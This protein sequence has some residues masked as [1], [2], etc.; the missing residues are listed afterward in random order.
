MLS[1]H[2]RN[3]HYPS[4]GNGNTA[5]NTKIGKL[6]RNRSYEHCQTITDNQIRTLAHS[7]ALKELY[8]SNSV[9]NAR[10][11][12]IKKVYIFDK[13]FE[14]IIPQKDYWESG[15]ITIDYRTHVYFTDGSVKKTGSGYGI[16]YANEGYICETKY[17]SRVYM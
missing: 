6:Y 9:F 4:D 2:K 8:N 7:S 1:V 13:K 16:F 11:D 3:E 12:N 15:Q 14:V 17:I 5:K 10:V